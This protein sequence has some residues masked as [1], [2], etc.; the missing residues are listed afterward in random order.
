MKNKFILLNAFVILLSGCHRFYIP[1]P[2]NM[3]YPTKTR[4]GIRYVANEPDLNHKAWWRKINDNDLNQLIARALACNNQIRSAN[5]TIIEAQAQLKAA[6]FAWIPTLDAKVNGFTGGTWNANIQPMGSLAATSIF[7]NISNLRFRGYYAGFAPGYTFNIL[8]NVSNV[9]AANASLA[10]KAAQ[11]Q[12]M[13]LSIIGQTTGAYFMLL[14]Q[15]EQL[16]IERELNND[17]KKLHRLER[18]RFTSG[19]NDIE[20]TTNIEQQIAQEEAKIPQIEKVI[21][22]TENTVHLLINDNPGALKTHHSLLALNI[23]PLMLKSI[24]SSVLKERPDIMIALNNIKMAHAQVGVAYSAF[25]PTIALTSLIGNASLDLTQLLKLSTTFWIAQANANAHIINASS[26]Q[27]IKV[28]KAALR[29]S[30]YDYIQTL[31][32]AFA[33]VDDNVTNVEMNKRTYLQTSKAYF[34]A[35]KTFNIAMTQYKAGAKDYRNVVNAK[36]N[37]ERA[38]LRL[39][40][41]KAQL[42][43]SLVQVYTALAGGADVG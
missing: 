23:K 11:A 34:A 14:S 19:A 22:Q 9:K 6:Q 8:N 24:P 35:Q 25:F 27:N 7:S 13:R 20:I 42:L 37:L 12:T 32:S 31:R 39:V 41:E 28:A 36:I 1:L 18:A 17:I 4:E 10:V 38:K 30:Y 40:Q 3:D 2:P 26:Y 5:E 29:T 21:A 15:R 33:D 16:A 43:D